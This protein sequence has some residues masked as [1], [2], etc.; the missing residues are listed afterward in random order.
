VASEIS[1]YLGLPGQAISY[2]VGERAWLDARSD[3]KTRAG[4]QFDLKQFHTRA[5]NLG[6]MGLDQMKREMARI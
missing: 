5:L 2:K 3:A 4:A 6:P 1:R